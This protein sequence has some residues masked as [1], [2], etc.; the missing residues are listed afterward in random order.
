[1][2]NS[3]LKERLDNISGWISN[4]DQKSSIMLAVIAFVSPL[5]FNAGTINIVSTLIIEPIKTHWGDIEYF[6]WRNLLLCICTA[7]ST[8]SLFA[9]A[10]LLILSLTAKVSTKDYIKPGL[11]SN[12]LI[13]FANISKLEYDQ[14]KNNLSKQSDDSKTN[15]ICHFLN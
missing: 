8:I 9:S 5:V 10:I 2:N 1:M 12:S 13:H 3:E 7:V 15:D 11:T 6:S 14:F 4:C